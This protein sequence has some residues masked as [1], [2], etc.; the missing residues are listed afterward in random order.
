MWKVEVTEVYERRHK[1]YEKKNTRVLVA[2]LGNLDTY[3]KT[4]K[5]GTKAQNIHYGFI[6]DESNGVKRLTPEGG[7]ASFPGSALR[8]PQR[9]VGDF[10][11][12]HTW[13]QGFPTRRHSILQELRIRITKHMTTGVY[14]RTEDSMPRKKFDSIA[15]MVRDVS[16]DQSFA[17][18]FENHM[19]GQQVIQALLMLRAAKG[20]NQKDIADR[21]KCTQSRISKLESSCDGDLRLDDLCGYASALDLSVAIVLLKT[22]GTIVDRVKFHAAYIKRLMDRLAELSKDDESTSRGF[23]TFCGEAAFN[24]LKIIQDAAKVVQDARMA[25][26]EIGSSPGT[27]DRGSGRYR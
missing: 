18:E 17:D 20:L 9:T 23:R 11:L 3:L 24:L 10:A 6:H 8:L 13:G 21:I 22:E 12:D 2:I 15:E 16:D 27:R 26:R 14:K 1:R 4:L 7:K 25:I 5:S 19:K